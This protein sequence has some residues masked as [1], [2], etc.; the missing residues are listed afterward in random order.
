M[1]KYFLIIVGFALFMA[2][3]LVGLREF[4]EA[5]PQRQ[6]EFQSIDTMKYSRDIS[7][8]RLRDP[9]FVKE[10]DNQ[11]AAIAKTG[12]THVAIATPYD[13]EFLPMM[14]LWVRA[15]RRNGLKVWFRGNWSGWEGWYNY[16]RMSPE[17]HQ[18]K[19]REFILANASLFEDGDV[20]TSCPE[21][22]NGPGVNIHIE[23][24]VN[25]H[26]Q[27]L[28]E[29]YGI[30]KEA[31]AEIGKDVRAN[32]YSMNYDLAKAMMDP[33]TTAAL[34][35]V[36]VVDHYVADPRALASDIQEIAQR[37]GGT[38]I[39]G[40]FGAPIPNLN[41]EMTPAQQKEWL[42]EAMKDLVKVQSLKGVNYWVN[43]GGTTAIWE[44]NGRERPAVG[45]ISQVF[46]GKFGGK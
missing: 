1:K 40:E 25:Q 19:T 29:E 45:I 3:F 17:E 16:P 31:F 14:K 44:E 4:A 43:A 38:V 2:A 23:P 21:C 33:Q 37:S 10:V 39:L 34:D 46:K 35:G 13:G 6:W 20:F 26:R 18:A 24:N 12:A 15:A 28:I 7:Q 36:V 11:V 30:A 9:S 27:F 42:E 8:D 32:F 5:H 22:E 41:G